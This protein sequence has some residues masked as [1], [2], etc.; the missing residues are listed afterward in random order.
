MWHIWD[1]GEVHAGFW[2]GDMS[3]GDHL[4]GL[5]VHGRIIL[6]WSFKTWD[7]AWTGL[8][9]LVIETGGGLL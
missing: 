6:K 4:E 3:E 1:K 7:G 2:W 5:G 9:W 8:I